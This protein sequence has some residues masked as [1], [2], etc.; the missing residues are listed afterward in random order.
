[1][2]CGLWWAEGSMGGWGYIGETWRIR[3]KR[4]CVTEMRPYV[5]LLRPLVRLVTPA[6]RV[7]EVSEILTTLM[8]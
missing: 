2:G 4:L 7:R 1:M 3:L 8:N 5:K 6:E